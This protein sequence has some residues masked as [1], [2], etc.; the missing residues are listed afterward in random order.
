MLLLQP[1]A[2]SAFPLRLLRSSEAADKKFTI[3]VRA[4]LNI[5]DA[6]GDDAD[7]T[8][9]RTSFLAGVSADYNIVKSFS[10]N[11]GLFYTGKGIKDLSA[12]F[13]ELPSTP[14]IV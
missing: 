10:I 5:A 2:L 1:F 11:S 14:L 12:D 13:I 9:S 3:G 6:S 8:K 4:G 7:G